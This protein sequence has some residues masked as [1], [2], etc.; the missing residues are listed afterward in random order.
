MAAFD[1]RGPEPGENYLRDENLHQDVAS[2]RTLGA[3]EGEAQAVAELVRR[4][5]EPV[6]LD[7][8]RAEQPH[9][10]RTYR[11]LI[12]QDGTL[13]WERLVAVRYFQ[14]EKLQKQLD[15]ALAA[16]GALAAPP[17]R[18]PPLYYTVDDLPP[19]TSER[20]FK[21]ALQAGLP[22]TRTG[23]AEVVTPSAW[24]TWVERNAKPRTRKAL[25]ATPTD[26]EILAS[27]GARRSARRSR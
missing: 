27:P 4:P 3:P 20:A 25:G 1:D 23:Y 21:R 26:D 7:P 12:K 19:K 13:T 11:V 24:L 14:A 16:L 10:K 8:F 15:A 6:D 9:G 18:D 5:D 17:R 22:V 2:T